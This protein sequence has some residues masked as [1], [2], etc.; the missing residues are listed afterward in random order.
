MLWTGLRQVDLLV[1][2]LVDFWV[3]RTEQ[4][5]ATSECLQQFLREGL[6][7]RVNDVNDC[8][9]VFYGC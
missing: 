5:T 3:G 2:E 1:E 7:R 6:F 8:V 4:E 9:I